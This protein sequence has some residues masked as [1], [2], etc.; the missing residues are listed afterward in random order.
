MWL[1]LY[2]MVLTDCHL[3][4]LWIKVILE[5]K[6]MVA[7]LKSAVNFHS[8]PTFQLLQVCNCSMFLNRRSCGAEEV[9]DGERKGRVSYHI[10][11]G[12]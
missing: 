4:C 3:K 8:M 10:T 2:L 11:S 5:I 6:L 1:S 12:N 7:V 9:E